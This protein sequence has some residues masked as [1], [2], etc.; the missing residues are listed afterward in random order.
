MSPNLDA[1][2]SYGTLHDKLDAEAG[3]GTADK[4]SSVSPKSPSAEGDLIS[5]PWLRWFLVFGQKPPALTQRQWKLLLILICSDAFSSYDGQIFNLSLTQ[6]QKEW[7][8][9]DR[10]VSSLGSLISVGPLA[11]L[12]LLL[13][14]D[15][16][17]RRTVL[18]A[19][20]L[21]YSLF[22]F[23]SAFSRSSTS[24]ASALFAARAF[25]FAEGVIANVMI[26]EEMP[27][28]C[29]GWAAGTLTACAAIGNGL[30]LVLFGLLGDSRG[31]SWR[32]LYGIAVVPLLFLA[33]IRGMLPETARFESSKRSQSLAASAAKCTK[34]QET[35]GPEAWARHVLG[36]LRPVLQL[37]SENGTRVAWILILTVISSISTGPSRLYGFKYLQVVHGFRARD[38][39]QLG[40]V[41]GLIG[42]LVGSRAGGL[43]DRLGRR[44]ILAVCFLGSG[45]LTAAYYCVPAGHFS[46]YLVC[47]L[48]TLECALGFAMEPLTKALVSESFPTAS[49]ASA[50]G[51]KQLGVCVGIPAGILAEGALAT[52]WA[53][54]ASWSSTAVV[55]SVAC[56]CAP[57]TFLAFPETAGRELEDIPKG[58]G[59]S[60][61]R[62]SGPR[63]NNWA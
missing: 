32:W 33:L 12:P 18:M 46:F 40:I 14:A 56:L 1:I 30:A 7:G 42:L 59:S 15:R 37:F 63:R 41:G 35:T 54:R 62:R 3:P 6:I 16:C 51:I 52:A 58:R 38:V 49:R 47:A 23:A 9:S 45:L 4:P 8:I 31:G 60:C 21:P 19:T 48:W 10:Q 55:G 20:I 5:L 25:T 44:R 39:S 43:S 29:R 36:A 34:C 17:G 53:T 22:T 27:P 13:A 11:G 61:P 26:A 2:S 24:L 28:N 50:H 57:L